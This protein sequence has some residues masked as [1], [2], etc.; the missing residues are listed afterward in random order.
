MKIFFEKIGTTP[1]PIAIE[2][3]GIKLE[4]TLQKNGYRKILLETRLSGVV[5]LDCDRCGKNYD[6][7]I[8]GPLKL[9]LSDAVSEDKVDLDIIEFLDGTIDISYIL[10]GEINAIRESYHYCD[11]CDCSDE[12]MEVEF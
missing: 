8:D 5:N 1:K 9:T 11:D 6:H 7:S 4:G 3:E 12:S 10:E 2:K